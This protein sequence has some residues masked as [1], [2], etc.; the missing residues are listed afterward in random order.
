MSVL[1]YLAELVLT[2]LLLA[3]ILRD[4]LKFSSLLEYLLL[5]KYMSTKEIDFF[6]M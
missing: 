1:I 5:I 4:D 6:V 3:N 2:W